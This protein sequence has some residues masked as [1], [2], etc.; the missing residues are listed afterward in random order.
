MAEIWKVS[1]TRPWLFIECS[2]SACTWEAKEARSRMIC[3][4]LSVPT[5]AR[6]VP[7]RI[8]WV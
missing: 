1:M 8:S 4:T 3:S 7:E 6:R 5:T 2:A